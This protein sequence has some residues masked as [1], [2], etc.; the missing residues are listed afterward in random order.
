VAWVLKKVLLW[1]ESSFY[2]MEMPPLRRPLLKVIARSVYDSVVS[3]LKNATTIILACSV[4]VWF[5]ASYPKPSEG[6]TGNPVQ[7][8]YAGQLG[9]AIEPVI[10]PLGFN[11]EIGIAILSSFP[12]REVFVTTL[13]TIYNISNDDDEHQGLIKTLQSRNN[14]GLFST[15]TALSLMVFY[16]FACQC[17]STLAVCKRETGSWAWTLGMFGYMTTL[18]YLASLAVYQGG[19]LFFQ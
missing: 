14:D 19:K 17:M 18:A 9:T 12:A 13:S 5:L 2:V 4:I 8:S 16:V 6:F 7:A 11:W 1:K 3:F 10:K 15:L